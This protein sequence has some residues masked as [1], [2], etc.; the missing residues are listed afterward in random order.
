MNTGKTPL[1]SELYLPGHDP[2]RN[3]TIPNPPPAITLT[4]RVVIDTAE[5]QAFTFDG[6]RSDA[7][8]GGRSLIVE[9]V[10]RC[11]GR[12]PD[13]LGD[14]SIESA[15]GEP[16]CAYVERKSLEDCQ[17]TLLG[18]GDRHRERFER[19]L[20]NLQN[21]AAALVVVECEFC[22]LLNTAPSYGSRSRQHNAKTLARSVLSLM[23]KYRV[24]WLFAGSRR[25]AEIMTFRFL[26]SCWKHR[27]RKDADL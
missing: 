27:N 5:Q 22:E 12:Y 13:S 11:L 18:F 9:T 3:R 24:P 6:M 15:A 8:R 4:W 23:R 14:Y 1:E 26:E 2:R 10:R 20:S 21:T 16:V 19:E 25:M 7:D 17:T